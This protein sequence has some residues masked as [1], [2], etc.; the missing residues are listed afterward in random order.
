M[1]KSS[2]SFKPGSSAWKLRKTHGRPRKYP[3][4]KALWDRCLEYLDWVDKNPF[5]IPCTTSYHGEIIVKYVPKLRPPLI[6]ELQTFLEI[7]SSTWA[8]Y[9]LLPDYQYTIERVENI[10]KSTKLQ[11][12]MI[13]IFNHQIVAR[14]LGLV[15][16]RQIDSPLDESLK[17]ILDEIGESQITI[18]SQGEKK[19]CH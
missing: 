12:A 17:E 9:K 8:S 5:M 6:G 3:T 13:D 4:A 19:P 10:I 15:D 18:G 16:K 11:G 7:D 14:D 1:A 2:T